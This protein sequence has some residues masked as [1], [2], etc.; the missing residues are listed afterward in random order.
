MSCKLFLLFPL[1]KMN[2]FNKIHDKIKYKVDIFPIAAKIAKCSGNNEP[3]F[4]SGLLTLFI[5][6][7]R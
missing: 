6:L 7:L 4:F 3:V 1:Y 5:L 2:K